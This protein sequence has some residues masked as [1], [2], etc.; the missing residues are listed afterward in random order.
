MFW[1]CAALSAAG[2]LESVICSCLVAEL[3][4]YWLHR[5]LH[6]DK[7][8][9]LSRGHMA[10]HLLLYGPTQPMRTEHYRDATSG[11]FSLGNV[12]LEWLA[13]SAILLAFSWGI[14]FLIHVRPIYQAIVLGNLVV[15]PFFTFSFL[16][17]A[18]HLRD[19]W[20]ARVPLINRWFRRARR[21][22]DIHHHSVNG[23]GHMDA[24]FG[25]GF[26][27]FDRIFCTLATRHRPLN[28][29]GLAIALQRYKLTM[30]LDSLRRESTA[31]GE[32]AFQ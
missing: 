5:L 24:N 6:S 9:F 16:H 15:W 20:M 13:P 3:A 28:C 7:L 21:L 23:A 29:K 18:M 17:D 1:F 8:P 30:S 22:H 31:E 27:L 32:A 25:I 12:G 4:G 19:F 10:H 2:V 14:M 11:R 26:F